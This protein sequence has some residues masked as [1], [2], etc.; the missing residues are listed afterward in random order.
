MPARLTKDE[1]IKRARAKHGDKYDY[2]EVNYVNGDTKVKIIC[3][4]H[5]AFWQTPHN[6]LHGK[7]GRGC[8]ICGKSKPNTTESFIKKARAIHG[9]KYGYSEVKFTRNKDKV[10][11]ICPIHGPF[12]QEAN[13]HLQGHGCPKCKSEVLS[14]QYYEFREDKIKSAVR[15]KYGVSS[16][17]Q[18]P[19]TVNTMEATKIANGTF[20][21][22]KSED[23]MY[24][25]LCQK[26]GKDDVIRQYK[27]VMQYPFLVDFFIPSRRLFIELNAN[28]VH[29]DHWFDPFKDLLLIQEWIHK[30]NPSYK[31]AVRTYTI[32]DVTKRQIARIN[33]LNYAVFWDKNLADF[34]E[35]L[36]ADAPDTHDYVIEYWWKH[37]KSAVKK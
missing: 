29:G 19:S 5:G 4:I 26:F 16:T 24:K 10:K 23:K 37:N 32:R 35:W 14:H 36:A 31:S 2:S 9:N 12:W 20:H 6:H 17:M 21:S 1:F 34:K 30:S 3:P 18:L 33:H 27:D 8:P 22:S 11:I 28:W 7:K 15:E 13:S 25:L